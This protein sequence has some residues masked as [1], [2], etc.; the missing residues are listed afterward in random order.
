MK[1]K[2]T[3]LS[4]MLLTSMHLLSMHVDDSYAFTD[5]EEEYLLTADEALQDALISA[6]IYD[7]ILWVIEH[8]E[9]ENERAQMR[10]L[11]K[12]MV[13]RDRI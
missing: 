1:F 12:R 6:Y 3:F 8:S 11:L 5:I 10:A 7:H 4:C 9:S 13:N 2:L